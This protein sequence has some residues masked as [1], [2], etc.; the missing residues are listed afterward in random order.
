VSEQVSLEK[1]MP[2][3]CSSLGQTTTGVCAQRR[4]EFMEEFWAD[5]PTYQNLGHSKR[6]DHSGPPGPRR[7]PRLLLR[8]P[9]FTVPMGWFSSKPEAPTALTRQDRQK[10]WEKRDAYFACLDAANV[11]KAGDEGN[12][13]KAQNEEY[14]QNC[15]KSWVCRATTL[16]CSIS[17]MKHRLNISTN[18]EY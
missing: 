5:N 1:A 18:G 10:C 16:R 17:L 2:E 13:C 11:L 8:L 6:P 9:H 14:E 15:A 3:V 4:G 7:Q 12:A